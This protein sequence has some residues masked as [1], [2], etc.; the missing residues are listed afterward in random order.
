[1]DLRFGQTIYHLR[2][3]RGLSQ[4]RVAEELKVTRQ[5]ISLWETD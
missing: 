4:E 1:M 3:E 5:N 2:K